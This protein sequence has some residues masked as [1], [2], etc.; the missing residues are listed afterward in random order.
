MI[1]LL[2]AGFTISG[3]SQ[4]SSREIDSREQTKQEE[5]SRR[6]YIQ[7]VGDEATSSNGVKL[8]VIIGAD[9]KF[10]LQGKEDAQIFDQI[11][12]DIPTFSLLPDALNYLSDKGFVIETYS[13]TYFGDIIK[14]SMILS[15]VSQSK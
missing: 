15:R 14:H 3:Y 6:V 11:T 12:A 7:L 4:S 8:N 1:L 10:Y 9:N 5:N 13:T 2:L